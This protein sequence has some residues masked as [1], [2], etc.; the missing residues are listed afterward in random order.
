MMPQCFW[1]LCPGRLTPPAVPKKGNNLLFVHTD[2]CIVRRSSRDSLF[3]SEADALNLRPRLLWH[4][5]TQVNVVAQRP[6]QVFPA[7]L[8]SYDFLRCKRKASLTVYSLVSR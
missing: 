1:T 3:P 8:F 6:H 4:T 2:Q 5:L 7:L